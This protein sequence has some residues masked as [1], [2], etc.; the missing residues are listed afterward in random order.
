MWDWSNVL[1][2]LV[3]IAGL[4]VAGITFLHSKRRES[5][6]DDRSLRD[7]VARLEAQV[8]LVLKDVSFAASFAAA[9]TLHRHDDALQLD[10]LIDKFRQH[11]LAQTEVPLFI[12]R[13]EAVMTHEG[14][15]DTDR[16]AADVL[17]RA[18]RARYGLNGSP[19]DA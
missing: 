10:E 8:E 5:E 7:R 14:R 11:R 13:L 9:A 4:A 17:L 6:T 18:L 15:T 16:Y 19:T 1:T 3:A 12:E 2:Q